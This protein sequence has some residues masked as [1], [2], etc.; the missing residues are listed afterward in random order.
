MQAAWTNKP[1]L[2]Y[3]LRNMRPAIHQLS[4]I[5]HQTR[6]GTDMLGGGEGN[7]EEENENANHPLHSG[8]WQAVNTDC[9]SLDIY[10]DSHAGQIPLYW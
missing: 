3:I 7:A 6:T 9:Y 8:S 2:K 5:I 10:T 4:T 1:Y